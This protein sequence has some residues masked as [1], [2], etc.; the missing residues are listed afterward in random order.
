MDA[1]KK[2]SERLGF[3]SAPQNIGEELLHLQY[4][5]FRKNLPLLYLTLMFGVVSAALAFSPETSALFR[6]IL[7]VVIGTACCSRILWWFSMRNEPINPDSLQ[8]FVPRTTI[9]SGVIGTICGLWAAFG[10]IEETS[11]FRNYIPAF[12]ALGAFSTAFCLSTMPRTATYAVL[13]GVLPISIM[14]LTSGVMIDVAL[15]LTIMASTLFLIG[16]IIRQYNQLTHMIE[17]QNQ[18]HEMA[19]TD[20][21]TALLNRRAFHELLDENM[22]DGTAQKAMSLMMMDLDRFKQVNDTNGHHVGD[23]LL[24]EL[25]QRIT[26]HVG[27]Y[28]SVARLGGDEFAILFLDYS[29]TFCD[30]AVEALIHKLGAAYVIDGKELHI[31]VSYG[32]EHIGAGHNCKPTDILM[33]VDEKLY[34]MKARTAP[35]D[36]S[37]PAKSIAA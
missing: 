21:L 17:L 37:K 9:I 7:P 29:V 8:N 12:M 22:R 13:S 25:A 2:I 11:N 31:G 18:M 6:I 27:E 24:K 4:A 19:H 23:A 20:S 1:V 3:V 16:L 33:H 34:A 35:S 28:A 30:Q 5:N 36:I 26:Q 10:W 15:G 32:L 14:L